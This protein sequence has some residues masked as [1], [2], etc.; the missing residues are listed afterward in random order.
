MHKNHL[1]QPLKQKLQRIAFSCV[2]LLLISYTF[3]QTVKP[4][5]RC[6]NN[7]IQCMPHAKT[8]DYCLL[9]FNRQ[10][11]LTTSESTTAHCSPSILPT[12]MNCMTYGYRFDGSIGCVEC[13]ENYYLDFTTGSCDIHPVT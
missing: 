5:T 1:Q 9:C 11:I 4:N 3:E 7:C 6:G 12:N 13:K 2:I 8:S 10:L